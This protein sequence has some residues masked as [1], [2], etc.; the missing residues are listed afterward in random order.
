M[1]E[2]RRV[3]A[4]VALAVVSPFGLFA[5]SAKAGAGMVVVPF[6]GCRSDGQTGPRDAPAG[7]AVE[8]AATAAEA[9]QLA[10]YRSAEGYGVLAPRGWQCFAIYGSDGGGL[11]VS[12][13]PLS[14]ANFLGA[15][16]KPLEG[17]VVAM[18]EALGDTSGRFE[19]AKVMARVFPERRKFVEGV[20]GEGI[21]PASAFPFGPYAADRL[22]YQSSGMVEYRTAAN[23][24]GLGTVP[25]I[26]KDKEAISG[27][28]ALVGATP[29]L[30]LAAV[31][32]KASEA[33]LTVVIVRQAE[34]EASR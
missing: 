30:M 10:Y 21:E 16:A 29:D 6:V 17:E 3:A 26:A 19:V 15:G 7:G 9:K 14:A 32:L 1:G 20:I 33:G 22:T 5:Q 34:R 18:T 28:A 25:R 23:S 11:Y 4:V 2:A 31:R 8:V 13:A 27:V 12:P 24:E